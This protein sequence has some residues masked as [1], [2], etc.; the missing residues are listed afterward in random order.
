MPFTA[1]SLGDSPTRFRGTSTESGA[2]RS[3][4][5]KST[6]R[7]VRRTGSRWSSLTTERWFARSPTDSSMRALR[8][9]G[10]LSAR[11]SS[12]Q[13]TMTGVGSLPSP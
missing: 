2:S 3:M 13:S 1:S 7:T 10:V 8:P 4:S 9:A 5:M 6:W 12:G 11:R